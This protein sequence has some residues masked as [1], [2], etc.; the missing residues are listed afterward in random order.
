MNEPLPRV[1]VNPAPGGATQSLAPPT[2]ADADGAA[3]TTPPLVLILDDLVHSVAGVNSALLASVDGFSVARSSDMADSAAHAAVLAAGMGLAHQLAALSGGT[4]LRQ[5]VV[6]H[7]NGLL[8]LWPLGTMRV[9]A[10][11][12]ERNVDQLAMR[13]FVQA[14]AYLL[15]ADR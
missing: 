1:P 14:K 2:A 7:D 9:L 10:L 6:D 11:L 12:T 8:L 4:E 3:Q 5:L 13:Q 15:A